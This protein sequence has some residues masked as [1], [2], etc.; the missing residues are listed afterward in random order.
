MDDPGKIW[1]LLLRMPK[2]GSFANR[3]AFAVLSGPEFPDMHAA[4]LLSDF[5][6]LASRVSTEEV[7]NR[8]RLER[9]ERS[10][11]WA[12]ER[13]IRIAPPEHLLKDPLHAAKC[14]GEQLFKDRLHAAKCKAIPQFKSDYRQ[15]FLDYRQGYLKIVQEEKNYLVS[16][17]YS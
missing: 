8:R 9:M 13:Y 2:A 14:K 5:M 10:F 17:H 16:I 3:V 15:L 1:S 11:K 7:A 6:H 4:A 12:K